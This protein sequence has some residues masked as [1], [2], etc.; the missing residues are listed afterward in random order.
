MVFGSIWREEWKYQKLDKG[1]YNE[2][3]MEGMNV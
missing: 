3:K 1:E 2:V